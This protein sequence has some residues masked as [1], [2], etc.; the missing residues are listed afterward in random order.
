MGAR[1]WN[2]EI[3]P[4][5][6]IHKNN[7]RFIQKEKDVGSEKNG[8]FQKKR[9]RLK[10]WWIKLSW[11]IPNACS[12]W[13]KYDQTHKFISNNS[14]IYFSTTLCK[15]PYS[16]S[17]SQNTYDGKNIR[18]SVI[19]TGTA[20]FLDVVS[21]SKD[22]SKSW[23]DSEKRLP[24][25][26]QIIYLEGSLFVVS[27]LKPGRRLLS[28][29]RTLGQEH[30]KGC[31]FRLPCIHDVARWRRIPVCTFNIYSLS[32]KEIREDFTFKKTSKRFD[33]TIL[34]LICN[35]L[36]ILYSRFFI[37]M[38]PEIK[39]FPAATLRHCCLQ[40]IEMLLNTRRL[41][42]TSISELLL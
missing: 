18:T 10:R 19:L 13:S 28:K 2:V 34:S 11:I 36:E 12:C 38:T 6:T 25:L 29:D 22:C 23:W 27:I 20:Y 17:R 14:N 37:P 8:L 3:F 15:N 26:I 32:L 1:E 9:N 41:F 16:V 31:R 33:S 40:S 30:G 39:R 24:M 7:A 4:K 21:W 35:I 42:Y 5:D